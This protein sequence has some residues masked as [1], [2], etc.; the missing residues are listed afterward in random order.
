MNPER[1][2]GLPVPLARIAAH[3]DLAGAFRGAMDSDMAI[4]VKTGSFDLR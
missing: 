3:K 4:F 2:Y 1:I